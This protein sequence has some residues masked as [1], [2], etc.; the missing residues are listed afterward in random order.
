VVKGWRRQQPTDMIGNW[1]WEGFPTTQQTSPG[2]ITLSR[3]VTSLEDEAQGIARLCGMDC[4]SIGR[5]GYFSTDFQYTSCS[6][7]PRPRPNQG[8]F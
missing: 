4:V 2:T 7:Y 1:W 6:I 3:V 8:G 5:R